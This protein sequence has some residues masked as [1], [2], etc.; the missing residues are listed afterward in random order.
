MDNFSDI[1]RYSVNRFDF[2]KDASDNSIANFGGNAK[3][4]VGVKFNAMS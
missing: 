1:D 3:L 4:K 2:Q